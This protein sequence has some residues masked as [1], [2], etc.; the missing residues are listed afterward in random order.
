MKIAVFGG[1]FDPVHAGHT[2]LAGAVVQDGFA[3]R[4]LFMPAFRPPH[5]PDALITPYEMRRE[6]LSL[7]LKNN[8]LFPVS[9]V[10][11]ERGGESFT[12]D[13]LDTLAE[14]RP[15]DKIMLLIGSDNL[16]QLHTWYQAHRLL[17]EY[18]I[19]VYPREDSTPARSELLLHWSEEET[20]KLFASF[21]P[22]PTRFPCS[23]SSIRAELAQGK[24][25]AAEAFLEPEVLAYI[26]QHHLY[27][28]I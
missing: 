17:R 21:L 18:S 13:T 16:C 22:E 12:I 4:V 7:A 26:K 3:D 2:G 1:T 10:E 15:D 5:K 11:F 14:N 9:D 20:E 19:L 25:D 6:M 24:T 28:I 8:P 23:S 27:K